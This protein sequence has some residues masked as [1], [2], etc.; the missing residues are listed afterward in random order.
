MFVLE[1]VLCKPV[2][3]RGWAKMQLEDWDEL[4]VRER[5]QC[6]NQTVAVGLVGDGW[7]EEAVWRWW[8]WGQTGCRGM[9]MEMRRFSQVSEWHDCIDLSDAISFCQ[10]KILCPRDSLSLLRIKA[11]KHFSKLRIQTGGVLVSYGFAAHGKP[12]W[13][14]IWVKFNFSHIFPEPQFL[15]LWDGD[16]DP[17]PILLKGSSWDS[18]REW[19]SRYIVGYRPKVDCLI[20]SPNGGTEVRLIMVG[21]DVTL[22][23][24]SHGDSL[25]PSP[26]SQA[27]SFLVKSVLLT[28]VLGEG[29]WGPRG[30]GSP[31]FS[32]EVLVAEQHPW[33][34]DADL[35]R[36]C[37]TCLQPSH[38]AQS[39]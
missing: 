4:Q 27:I 13:S 37:S 2:H 26:E 24:P 32:P 1:R 17:H 8:Q 33:A 7:M 16:N 9:S 30:S 6:L 34:H 11:R 39:G 25:V 23:L 38:M 3:K 15:H 10:P 20:F 36:V 21:N 35:Q 28:G 31:S 12:C 19:M 29:W 5:Y 22:C 18:K 14:R